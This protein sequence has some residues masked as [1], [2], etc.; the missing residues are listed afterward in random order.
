MPVRGRKKTFHISVKLHF[1]VFPVLFFAGVLLA[2]L[3]WTD[4]SLWIGYQV[5]QA[6]HRLPGTE[7]SWSG[8][9][10]F[11]LKYRLP[12]WTVLC[13]CSCFDRGKPFLLAFS[14]WMGLSFGL[15]A[16]ILAAQ[17][18]FFGS[19]LFC[20][21]LFPQIFAWFP[22]YLGLLKNAPPAAGSAWRVRRA[23]AAICTVLSGLFFAGVS[24]EYFL[25][26]WFLQKACAVL[27]RFLSVSGR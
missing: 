13:V 23:R 4:E 22:A 18:S 2:N 25:N 3:R 12:V 26:P 6:L 1:M 27:D 20:I 17:F 24:G 19:L 5:E 16:A 8:F 10:E 11:L 7:R 21:L 15:T 14:G 9:A